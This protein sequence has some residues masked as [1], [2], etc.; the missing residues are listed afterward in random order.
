MIG[1]TLVMRTSLLLAFVSAPPVLGASSTPSSP[2]VQRLEARS[3]DCIDDPAMAG[4]KRFQGSTLPAANIAGVDLVVT[5]IAIRSSTSKAANPCG[6]PGAGGPYTIRLDVSLTNNAASAT[7]AKLEKARDNASRADKK[8]RQRRL[9][10]LQQ[11]E[12]EETVGASLIVYR[13]DLHCEMFGRDPNVPHDD[14][15]KLDDLNFRF[16]FHSI[17]VGEHG[18]ALLTAERSGTAST[19]AFV[20]QSFIADCRLLINV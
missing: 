20:P 13:G 4:L 10:E 18:P 6:D 19:E 8:D 1:P 16:S 5:G 7:K 15:A 3:V 14:R 2:V 17:R 11:A 12:A 9:A